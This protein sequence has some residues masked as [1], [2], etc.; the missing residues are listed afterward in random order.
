MYSSNL[1]VRIRIPNSTPTIPH[2][3]QLSNAPVLRPFPTVV[4]CA[5]THLK[6]PPP[7]PPCFDKESKALQGSKIAY[8]LHL[9]HIYS[10]ITL[11][12]KILA[13]NTCMFLHRWTKAPLTFLWTL[14]PPFLCNLYISIR[15]DWPPV[16]WRPCY[17][18]VDHVTLKPCRRHTPNSAR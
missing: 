16:S 9:S 15:L 4:V 1:N 14:R 10:S 3:R 7:P 13:T 18:L 11:P 2:T 6:W 17:G 8:S 12:R 5:F